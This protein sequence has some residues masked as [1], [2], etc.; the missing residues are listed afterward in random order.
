M[1]IHRAVRCGMAVLTLS[2]SVASCS[3]E[4][5]ADPAG[6]GALAAA[7]SA[8]GFTDEFS[9]IDQ[10]RWGKGT[11][12]L[13]KG[14]FREYNVFADAGDA[15]L[16]YPA[17][18]YDGGELRTMDRFGY[19]TYEARMRT[20][21]APG[22]ISAFFLYQDVARRNDEIDIEIFNDGTRRIMFT[23]WVADRQMSNVTRTLGFDPAAGYHTYRI[24]WSASRI[25][26]LVDGMVMH[27]VTK[28]NQIPSNAMKLM[29]NAWW[30]TWLSGPQLTEQREVRI[31][32][33]TA[34][35][36]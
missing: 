31:D 34:S 8:T 15:V 19:G 30:P 35:P 2:L 24:E 9:S 21:Y 17:S 29:A 11:H 10:N 33:I 25:R 36:N 12:A 27:E 6:I 26:F 22:T 16:A 1:K 7:T 4:L 28:R 20:A 13:G 14:F 3:P 32:R 18:S 23:T 5:P